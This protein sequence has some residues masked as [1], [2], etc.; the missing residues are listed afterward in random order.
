MLLQRIFEEEETVA[1]KADPIEMV[2]DG[3]VLWLV[4]RFLRHR[5]PEVVPAWLKLLSVDHGLLECLLP[6]YH[7]LY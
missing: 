6:L 7:Q 5:G 4:A 1:T 3:C 2:Q